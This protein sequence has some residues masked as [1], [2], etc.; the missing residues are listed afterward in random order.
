[1]EFFRIMH[2]K[3]EFKGIQRL[4]KK[5]LISLQDNETFPLLSNISI[6]EFIV[7]CDDIA[8]LYTDDLDE[9]IIGMRKKCNPDWVKEIRTAVKNAKAKAKGFK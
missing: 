6:H 5:A 2:E 4:I 3:P 9:I 1:M 8:L 7:I